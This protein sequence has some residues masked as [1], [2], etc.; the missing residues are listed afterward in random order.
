MP[1]RIPRSTKTVAV[2]T[3]HALK[4]AYRTMHYLRD[5]LTFRRLSNRFPQR[6]P[7]RWRD[8]LPC[9][10]ERMTA[11]PFDPHYIY[12]PAWAARV[13]ARIRPEYHVDISSTLHFCSIVSA[14]IPVRFFDFRPADLRLDNLFTGG[15]DLLSLPFPDGSIPSL[16]CMH[17]LEHVGLGRYGDP[18]D[19]VGDRKA[20]GELKRVLSQGGTL[21]A[22]VP[23]GRPRIQFN[24]HRIYSFDQASDLF[25][26]LKLEEF[27]L[28]T[29]LPR[30]GGFIPE[31]S[32]TLADAQSYG[33]GCFWFTKP[34][35][36]KSPSDKLSE[37]RIDTP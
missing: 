35:G 15:A 34:I 10:A 11:T 17:V 6:F 20:A 26:G 25:A 29:D 5:F 33:C 2:R 1:D 27:S 37:W 28:I 9:L 19:P 24:A 14:F 30:D 18:L 7:I 12:H 32:R 21:L 8:R 4:S 23:V 22:V 3:G 31:A 13:L 16:S 36:G